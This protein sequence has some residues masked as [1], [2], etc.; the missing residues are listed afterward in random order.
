VSTNRKPMLGILEPDIQQRHFQLA[1]LVLAHPGFSTIG[2]RENQRIMADSPAMLGI[3]EVDGGQ[4]LP[5]RHLRLNPAG[6]LVIG[7]E[8]VASISRRYRACPCMSY[9]EK[10]TGSRFAG[11]DGIANLGIVSL[12]L[13]RNTAL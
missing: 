5:G 10:Q 8:N 4:Q 11:L 12:R 3:S 1:I 6:A 2:G 9:V 7:V 13:E